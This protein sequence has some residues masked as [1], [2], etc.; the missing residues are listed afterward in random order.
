VDRAADWTW[1]ARDGLD[2]PGAG[3]RE[4]LQWRLR[5]QRTA[6]TDPVR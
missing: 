4:Y 1:A 3:E 6:S 2:H 5:V